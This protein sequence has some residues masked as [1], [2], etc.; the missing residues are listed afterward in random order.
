MV[1]KKINSKNKL[2]CWKNKKKQ[3]VWL[4]GK[5]THDSFPII[6][7]IMHTSR[8]E[9]YCLLLIIVENFNKKLLFFANIFSYYSLSLLSF[10]NAYP[11]LY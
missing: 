6:F 11:A 9:W 5:E 4:I 10:F 2:N 3:I 1:Q 7:V 8:F